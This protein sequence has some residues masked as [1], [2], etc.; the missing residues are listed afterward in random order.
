MGVGP[1]QARPTDR[2]AL[3]SGLQLPFIVRRAGDNYKLIGPA[4]IHGLMKGERWDKGLV[5]SITLV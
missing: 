2:I 3:I 4:Y 5:E 1:R